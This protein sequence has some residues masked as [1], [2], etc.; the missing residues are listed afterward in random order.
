MEFLEDV[1]GWLAAFALAD[2]VILAAK[3]LRRK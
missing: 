3:K 1:L 2:L